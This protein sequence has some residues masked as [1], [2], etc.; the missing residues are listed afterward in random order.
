MSAVAQID[1][2]EPIEP[3][4]PVEDTEEL[5][6]VEEKLHLIASAI[7][8]FVH[9]VRDIQECARNCVPQASRKFLDSYEDVKSSLEEN[10]AILESDASPEE[11]LVAARELRKTLRKS[12]R[13]QNDATI[14]T[15]E[16][17]LF[18]GMF[19]CFD[20]FVGELLEGVYSICPELY[21]GL[22]VQY[23]AAEVLE[24]ETLS[25]FKAAVLDK[26]IETVRR[27]SY[28]EQFKEFERRFGF[29]SLT[30]F[31][32]WP[33]LIEASQRR[34]LFTHCNGIVSQQYLKV[35]A[36]AG[37]KVPEDCKIGSQLTVTAKYF[38]SM[39][40]VVTE[41]G[42]MLGHTVWRKLLP[43]ERRKAD[44]EL[45]HLIYDFLHLGHFKMAES[46][47]KFAGRL[48]KISDDVMARMFT[49]NHA[50]AAKEIGGL[51]AAKKILEKK[52]WSAVIY[53]FKLAKAVL[54]EE[55][56]EAKG[57]MIRIGKEGDLV[58][59]EAYHDWPLFKKFRERQEFLDGYEEVYGVKYLAKL[60]E[61]VHDVQAETEAK[62][63]KTEAGSE[64]AE[65][66]A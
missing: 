11:K 14:T 60:S 37:Y 43:D 45:N 15:L 3:V 4:E 57:L 9:N 5:E 10:Q 41:V 52:D 50:I 62:D 7:E 12:K 30:K 35:C 27:K 34:N 29:E 58:C 1:P 31:D 18:I 22:G 65:I 66:V 51:N 61:I 55:Y 2:I 64:P 17:S 28:G 33:L 26:E 36:E 21:K 49:L 6:T 23:S 13:L 53:D 46:L 32:S 59:E 25:E 16:R 54:L 8:R 40:R 56:V 19:T 24:Y 47:C 38:Y 20:R 39:C 63:I 48:P 42:V 44:S